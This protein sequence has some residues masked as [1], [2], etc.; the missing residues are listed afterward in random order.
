MP[1]KTRNATSN[2]ATVVSL[3]SPLHMV[4]AS[5]S[6]VVT[7]N[8]SGLVSVTTTVSYATGDG[9]ARALPDYIPT[10]GNVTWPDGDSTTMTTGRQ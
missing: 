2:S 4:E 3:S 7:I 6:M 1:D 10:Q 9:A 8:R 5:E